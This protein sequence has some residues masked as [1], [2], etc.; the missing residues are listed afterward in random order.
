MLWSPAGRIL[1]FPGV[2]WG[3]VIFQSTTSAEGTAGEN[4]PIVSKPAA[5]TKAL[6]RDFMNFCALLGD[7]VLL[8]TITSLSSLSTTPAAWHCP[9][10]PP[11]VR[12]YQKS[13]KNLLN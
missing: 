2:A 10:R 8:G 7:L 12:S 5:T 4:R 13:T 9:G 3:G 11:M 6:D 1:T